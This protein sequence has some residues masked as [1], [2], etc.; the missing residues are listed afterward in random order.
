MGSPSSMALYETVSV[1][2]STGGYVRKRPWRRQSLT[3]EFSLV[4]DW[5]RGEGSSFENVAWLSSSSPYFWRCTLAAEPYCYMNDPCNGHWL[6]NF[7][8]ILSAWAESFLVPSH[9][10]PNNLNIQ[11]YICLVYMYSCNFLHLATINCLCILM[12]DQLGLLLLLIH[13]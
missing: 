1:C 10:L 13:E 4:Y 7:L 12:T 5:G 11:V 3:R 2:P 6:G 8:L 9:Q